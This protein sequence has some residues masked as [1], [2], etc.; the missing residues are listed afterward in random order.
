[1]RDVSQVSPSQPL[2]SVPQVAE[3]PSDPLQESAPR[4]SLMG[5][6]ESA[7]FDEAEAT[8]RVE[9]L[10]AQLRARPEDDA[11]VDELSRLL[12][13]L[14]RGFDLLALLSARLEDAPPETRARL[15]PRQRRVLGSLAEEA[16]RDGR[17]A[18]AAVFRDALAMLE[19]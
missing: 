15:L 1:M 4:T 6:R 18:E 19:D 8:A 3:V 17:A 10:T 9:E 12:T 14:D 5:T 7:V 13:A 2:P 16:D 11:V